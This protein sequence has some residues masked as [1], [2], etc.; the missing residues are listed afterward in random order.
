[1]LTAEANERLTRVGPGT[2][3]GELMRRYWIPVRP[4]AELKEKDVMPIRILGED[5]V[6]F[7]TK[8]GDLGLIGER[9]PHRLV[10]MKYGIPDEDGLRCCYH[11]WMFAPDGQCIDTPLE[12]PTNKLKEQVKIGS[13][14]V[15]EMGGL[16]WAYMGEEPAP[17]LPRWDQFVQPNTFRHIGATVLPCNWLQVLE[18]GGDPRHGVYLHGHFYRYVIER[19]QAEGRPVPPED[20][21]FAYQNPYGWHGYRE[22]YAEWFE[23][24]QR[25]WVNHSRPEDPP[26]WREHTIIMFP[27]LRGGQIGVP[28]DDTHTWHSIYSRP[29]GLKG[30]RIDAL[31][32]LM[33]RYQREPGVIK[34][35]GLE[36][37]LKPFDLDERRRIQALPTA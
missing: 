20:I 21:A 11:G 27:Y 2:P 13:Y 4:L 23:Y 3:M 30:A 28:I 31:K 33:K 32:Q 24:G 35:R 10:M 36:E 7:I 15:Q 25:K 16:V 5:L 29:D 6:L 12:S 19:M 34:T 1:M 18:N 37:L 26:A 17:L 14:P 22:M 9:C 8:K